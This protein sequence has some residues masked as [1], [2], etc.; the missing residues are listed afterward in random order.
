MPR[1]Y[2]R[3]DGVPSAITEYLS[4]LTRVALE[5]G[6]STA[7]DGVFRSERF[8]MTPAEQDNQWGLELES[9]TGAAN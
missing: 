9:C 2:D 5:S 4:N 1:A 6:A 3:T 8:S 7:F